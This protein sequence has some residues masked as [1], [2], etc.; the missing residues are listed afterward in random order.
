MTPPEKGYDNG[1]HDTMIRNLTNTVARIEGKL[2]ANL[3][4]QRGVDSRLAEGVVKFQHLED[5]Q[6]NN[7]DDI[8]KLK[9][10]DRNIGILSVIG[11]IVAGIIGTAK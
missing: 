8:E 11:N 4:W 7:K 9:D 2:D 6:K 1:V 10:R 5:G 3:E